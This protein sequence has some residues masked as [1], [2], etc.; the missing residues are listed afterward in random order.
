M[1]F[2]I[3]ITAMEPIFGK[4]AMLQTVNVSQN[5]FIYNYLSGKCMYF[6]KY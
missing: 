4:A 1:Y 3:I 6:C 5:D 2:L